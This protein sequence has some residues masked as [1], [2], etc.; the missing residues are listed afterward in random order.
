MSVAT[1]E[2]IDILLRKLEEYNINGGIVH[3]QRILLILYKEIYPFLSQEERLKGDIIYDQIQK[4]IKIHGT[5]CSYELNIL[6]VM[7]NFDFWIRDKLLE[8]GLL[9]SQTD[10]LDNIMLQ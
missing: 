1:L 6:E 5:V 9:M 4:S 8:K 3:M 2:R 7:N 10:K